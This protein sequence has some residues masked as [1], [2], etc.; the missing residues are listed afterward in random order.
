MSK[1]R[2]DTDVRHSDV[3]VVVV[4]AYQPYLGGHPRYR[5]VQTGSDQRKRRVGCVGFRGHIK[6]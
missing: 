5:A 2:G 1:F 4:A 3:I 6:R